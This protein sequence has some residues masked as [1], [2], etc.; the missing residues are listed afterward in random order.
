MIVDDKQLKYYEQYYFANELP[1]PFKVKDNN[2]VL[3]IRPVKVSMFPFYHDN[4]GIMTGNAFD[5]LT[6]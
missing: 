2:Y 5:Y 3:H 1:V 4:V 6:K